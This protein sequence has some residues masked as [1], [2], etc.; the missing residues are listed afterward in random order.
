[1]FKLDVMKN[2]NDKDFEIWTKELE[3]ELS[4]FWNDILK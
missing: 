1:M 3:R 4:C 2:N